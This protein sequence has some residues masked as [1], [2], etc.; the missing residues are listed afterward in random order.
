MTSALEHDELINNCL[1]KGATSFM[2]KPIRNENLVITM[3]SILSGETYPKIAVLLRRALREIEYSVNTLFNYNTRVS[4]ESF[5]IQSVGEVTPISYD[6]EKI[7]MVKPVKKTTHLEIQPP[8][9]SFSFVSEAYGN[10]P[11]KVVGHINNEC[12]KFLSYSIFGN[13]LDT[14][15]FF[16]LLNSKILSVIASHAGTATNFSPTRPFDNDVDKHVG[17]KSIINIDAK[18]DIEGKVIHIYFSIV[19]NMTELLWERF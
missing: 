6:I 10:F 3:L 15:E 9:D 13:T 1:K 17:Q 19:C 4:L 14:R 7:R 18:F 11:V 16:S 5:E 8:A 12:N 2:I